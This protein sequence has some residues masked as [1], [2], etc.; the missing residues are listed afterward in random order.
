LSE[1]DVIVLGDVPAGF[2]S[3]EQL[4]MFRDHVAQRGAGLLWIGGEHSVPST[5]SG[6]ALADLLPMRSPL[7]LQPITDPVTMVPTPLADRLGVLQ[8]TAGDQV[9][10]PRELAD[11]SYG[12]S[13]LFYAQQIEPSQ[14]KPAAEVLA[15]SAQVIHGHP[16][17]LVVAMRYGAGQSIYVATDETWRWRYGR[18]ELLH[19]Q[20]WVQM[21]R[22][23]GRESLSNSG[24]P[25][26]LE[27]NPRRV[28]VRQPVRLELRVLD[29]QMIESPSASVSVVIETTD[30]TK[31]AE[32]ELRRVEG[33][34]DRYAATFLP[35]TS[36]ELRIRLADPSFARVDLT[37]SLDVFAPDDELRRPETDHSLL[38]GLAAATNGKVLSP[39]ELDELPRLLPNRAVK[40][41]N[42]L[43]E[44]I[45]DT[46]LALI[47]VLA[48]L[49]AE[50]IGRKTLRLV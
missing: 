8:L 17:P 39:D 23:L 15:Q 41:I 5:Y 43:T 19:E 40:T 16:L 2:F 1:Y 22:M 35:D 24:D 3:N 18:G 36:G 34:E 50:W 10:W 46:P 26:R 32:M 7:N 31:V 42:P 21:I 45:W 49:T 28:A 48:L 38:A 27:A 12:W 37:A 14:L 30:G 25:A 11:P 13:R 44:P 4:E 47:L 29:A 20:F 9:G 33:A 6:T